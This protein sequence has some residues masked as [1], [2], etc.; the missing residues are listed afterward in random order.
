MSRNKV[1]TSTLIIAAV[2]LLVLLALL[3]RVRATADAVVVLKTTGITCGSCAS[4]IQGALESVKGVAVTEI[5]PARGEIIVGYDTKTVEPE[6]VAKRVRAAGFGCDVDAVLT[7]EQFRRITGRAIG[8]N[9][10]TAGGCCG[11]GGGCGGNKPS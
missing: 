1:I 11:K 4:R 2:T 8:Q 9:A 7:P 10:V 6:A 5:D 3:V